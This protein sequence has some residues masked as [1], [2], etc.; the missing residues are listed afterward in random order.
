M[1]LPLSDDD[2]DESEGFQFQFAPYCSHG[3]PMNSDKRKA[4]YE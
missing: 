4:S 2:E 1:S 3:Y